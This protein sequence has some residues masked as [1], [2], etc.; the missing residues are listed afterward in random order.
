MAV[1]VAA[2]HRPVGRVWVFQ[3][4][5]GNGSEVLYSAG[6]RYA[7]WRLWFGARA[8]CN[9]LRDIV[10]NFKI[11]ARGERLGNRVNTVGG[12]YMCDN[13]SVILIAYAVVPAGGH[14]RL[15]IIQ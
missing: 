10:S 2:V 11:C 14:I 8:P 12:Q 3:H 15:N 1:V 6:D 7:L 13:I 5:I 4:G 9:N